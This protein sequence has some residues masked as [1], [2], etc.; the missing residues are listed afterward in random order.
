MRTTLTLGALLALSAAAHAQPVALT[1]AVGPPPPTETK[2]A[3]PVED[4]NDLTQVGALC[5]ATR[6][7][8]RVYFHR[9]P[10]NPAAASDERNAYKAARDEA[11]DQLYRLRIPQEGFRLGD[12]NDDDN[13]LPL[14]LTSPPRALHGAI[15]LL[16]PAEPHVEFSI[17]RQ[18]LGDVSAALKAGTA[19]LVAY[20]ELNDEQ[21]AV[22][23]GSVAEQV[24]TIAALPV[25]FELRDG[26]GRELARADT[27]RA[28]QFR[29]VIGGYSGTPRAILGAV[30][31]DG[32]DPVLLS[33]HLAALIEP[34]RHCYMD[35]LKTR[36]DAGGTVVLGVSVTTAGTVDAVTFIADALGDDPLRQCVSDTFKTATFTDV[37]GLPALFRV[38]VE[39]RLSQR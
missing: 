3:K 1:G 27:P 7:A 8:D 17:T 24:Y 18:Q 31:A 11:M 21:G 13:L 36:N 9:D 33:Q 39:F 19:V 14:D 25:T 30:E 37:G 28:D 5:L 23:T 26:N 4:L 32:T 12:F 20:F 35:R 29:S 10:T 22:C 38:P 34:L 15:T 16:F 6:P 2:A